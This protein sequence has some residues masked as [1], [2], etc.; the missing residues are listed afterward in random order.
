MDPPPLHD[1]VCWILTHAHVRHIQ[2]P[3]TAAA[4]V[5]NAERALAVAMQRLQRTQMLVLKCHLLEQ[6]QRMPAGQIQD[7]VMSIMPAQMQELLD[8]ELQDTCDSRQTVSSHR[9]Q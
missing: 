3:Q 6:L 5:D 8:P 1:C 4:A 9:Q 2:N 7:M